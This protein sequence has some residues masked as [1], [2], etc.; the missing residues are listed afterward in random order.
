MNMI[1]DYWPKGQP[2]HAGMAQIEI[3]GET[4]RED[5]QRIVAAMTD[6]RGVF[7]RLRPEQARRLQ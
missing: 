1:C 6:D 5:A 2:N 4:T 3:F 7:V